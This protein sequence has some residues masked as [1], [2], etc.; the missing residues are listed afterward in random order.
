[1]AKSKLP[2]LKKLIAEMSETEL[3]EEIIKLYTKLPQVKDY[4]NQDLMSEEERQEVLKGF[5]D[6]IYKQFWTS[7]GNPRGMVNNTTIKGIISD[8]EKI[9]V[10]PYDVVDLLIYR[11]EEASDFANQF[12]GMADSNYN[13]SITAFKKAMKLINENNLKNHFEDRCKQIFKANNLDY[14]YT[15]QLEE[16][17]D[18]N[19]LDT[20]ED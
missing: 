7:G 3:R 9:A 16:L 14:W 17:F 15:E 1:M 20:D 13:A 2:D 6:K 18:E 8:Y 19:E 10:F 12:G 4:Y 11:V 5:K